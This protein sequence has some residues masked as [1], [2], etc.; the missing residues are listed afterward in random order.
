MTFL[1]DLATSAPLWLALLTVGVNAV[2]GALRASIDDSRHWDI[3]GL[4]TFALL[5]G[6]GGGFIRDMLIGNLPAESLR[7]PWFLT[8]VLGCIVLVLVVGQRLAKV[9][10]LVTLL[11]ALALGLFAVSGTS[12]ALRADLPV[13]SAV[14]VGTVSAVGGGV[15][16]SV[17]KDEV[18]GILL[19]SAPNA[20]V[21]VLSSGVYA[22]VAV[23]S[24]RAAAVAGI[25]AAIIAFYT[26]DALGLRTRRAVDASALLLTRGDGDD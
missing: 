1:P 7:T 13:I 20:L 2:V 19:T 26:A 22:G 5:M 18:P 25:A 21:A 10:P 17:M 8:T 14:F 11:N 15:L 24:A 4:S 23:W 16:V 12:A 3:V 6:L 9:A